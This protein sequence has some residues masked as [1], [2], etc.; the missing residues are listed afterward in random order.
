MV[1]LKLPRN[2]EKVKSIGLPTLKD[3]P[4]IET[5][6]ATITVLSV[7]PLQDDHDALEWLLNR[8][9]WQI[10]KAFTFSSAVALLQ[11]TRVSVVV[12]ERDLEPGT[13]RD[14]MDHLRLLPQPPYLI[15]TSRLAD[16]CLWA[17]A[18]NVG[19]YDVLAK[20]FDDTEVLRSLS[21]ACLHRNDQHGAAIQSP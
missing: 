4:E 15:V 6:D 8:R 14:M 7:S 18:L 20:P 3:S 13:W 11:K 10:R 19:A 17:E 16:E 5:G 2:A 1:P 9:Q 21:L 12:C